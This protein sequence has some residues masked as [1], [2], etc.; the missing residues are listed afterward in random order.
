MITEAS[1]RLSYVCVPYIIQHLNTEH[2]GY[3]N[4][5]ATGHNTITVETSAALQKEHEENIGRFKSFGI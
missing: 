1:R 3:I 5:T 4:H 2:S